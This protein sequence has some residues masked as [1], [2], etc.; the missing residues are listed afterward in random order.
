MKEPIKTYEQALKYL[1]G[2]KSRPYAHNTRITT[3]FAQYLGKAVITVTYHNNPVANFFPDG[4][5]T[6]SSC[7]WKTPT[8]KERINWFLPKGF[9]LYQKAGVWYIIGDQLSLFPVHIFAD[10]IAIKNGIVYNEGAA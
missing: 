5:I 1:Q 6:Y 2:K 4:T 3:F 9:H 10:G 7:G 8:T